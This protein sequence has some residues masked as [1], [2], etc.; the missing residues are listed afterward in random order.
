MVTLKANLRLEVS[1][2]IS[3][4]KQYFTNVCAHMCMLCVSTCAQGEARG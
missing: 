1:S 2:D 3:Q 4:N